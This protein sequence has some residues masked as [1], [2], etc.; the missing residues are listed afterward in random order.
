MIAVS[1]EDLPAATVRCFLDLGVLPDPA[2]A[3]AAVLDAWWISE[4]MDR[5][6]AEDALDT[7]YRRS[8][9]RR[10]REGIVTLHDLCIDYARHFHPA[11]RP[12]T[13]V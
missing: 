13:A 8:L 6:D 4:G 9:A 3:P 11:L 1:L 10:D 12:R 7:L 2:R 5:I